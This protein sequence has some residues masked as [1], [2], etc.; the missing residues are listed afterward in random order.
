MRE[1]SKISPNLWRSKRFN[2][3]ETAE[4]KLV[5]LYLL[6]CEHQNSAGAYRLP[7]GYAATDLGMPGKTFETAREGIVNADLVAFDADTDEYVIMRW[8]K[9]NPPM[10]EKHRMGIISLLEKL[11]S[12]VLFETA[13]NALAGKTV[14]KGDESHDHSEPVGEYG[15]HLT[16]SGLMQRQNGKLR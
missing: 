15:S 8:F 5:F 16:Q 1:F 11:D 4:E 2:G 7:A 14:E 3:L 9:H 12:E 6:T 13:L 10:N